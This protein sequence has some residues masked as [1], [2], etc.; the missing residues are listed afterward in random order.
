MTPVNLIPA[1]RMAARRR[2]A[3]VKAWSTV[4]PAVASMLM[5]GYG[6]LRA[7]WATDASSLSRDLSTA[8]SSMQSIN[9]EMTRLRGDIARTQMTIRANNAVGR[10]PDWGLLLL[11]IAS[12][13]RAGLVL[14]S[15]S[16]EPA[17]M[18]T[19]ASAPAP[20]GGRPGH[21]KLVL[22]GMGQDQRAVADF[23]ASLDSRTPEPLFEQVLLLE[24]RRR[25]FSGREA[26]SFRI[27]CA[28]SD[29][30]AEVK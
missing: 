17:T 23:V 13:V 2:A 28:L 30:A 18:P 22:T 8:D 27:E 7:A 15:C 4:V 10:Q 5:A 20:A 12:K 1:S 14:T 11:M 24:S 16:L 9:T 21:F 26:M 19:E 25:P 29:A 6:W 3:R